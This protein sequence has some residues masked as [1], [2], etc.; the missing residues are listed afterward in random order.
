MNPGFSGERPATDSVGRN[1]LAA[2]GVKDTYARF[3]RSEERAFPKCIA[4]RQ[5]TITNI[6]VSFHVIFV[7]TSLRI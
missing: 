4:Y 7:F 5:E 1:T 3:D 6:V 2:L